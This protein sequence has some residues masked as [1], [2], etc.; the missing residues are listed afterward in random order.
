VNEKKKIE[1]TSLCVRGGKT[2]ARESKGDV[3]S[4]R[5]L[6]RGGELGSEK[7]GLED[8][9]KTGIRGKAL[10]TDSYQRDKAGE[11]SGR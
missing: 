10:T 5:G 1:E 9:I 6:G 7:M 11:G 8:Q 3:K 4:R 2:E